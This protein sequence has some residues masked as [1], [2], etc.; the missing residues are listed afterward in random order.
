MIVALIVALLAFALIKGYFPGSNRDAANENKM[1]AIKV[2]VSNGC[3]FERLAADYA[4]YIK[5]KNIDVIRLTDTPKPIYN[6]SI[7]VVKTGD[8]QDLKRLQKMTGITR[9]TYAVTEG[10]EVPFIIILGA[11]YEDYM[12]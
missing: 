11:D 8:Q 1:P 10:Y 4:E 9:F 5:D 3:G 2:I 12:K 7:I 6:K